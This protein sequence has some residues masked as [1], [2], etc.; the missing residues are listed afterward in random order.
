MSAKHGLIVLW[1][2]IAVPYAFADIVTI[3]FEG[4]A[5]G[6]QVTAQ[7][8]GVTFTNATIA[9]S[10]I[11][12]DPVE[13]PP[14]S[15]T[16]VIFDDGGPMSI[17]FLQSVTNFQAFFTY[18]EP[19]TLTAFDASNQIVA[20]ATSTYNAN[21]GSSGNPPD[22]LLS[23]SFAGGISDITLEADP[24]G[25]SFVMDDMTYTTSDISPS[26]SEPSFLY[27]L[28]SMVGVLWGCKVMVKQNF[29]VR[30]QP[31]STA[32]ARSVAEENGRRTRRARRSLKPE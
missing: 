2:T 6:T 23:L 11:S 13:F 24:A 27:L 26:T 10:F 9:S 21:Y 32:K 5:D 29:A 25:S 30:L 31:G 18:A 4:L 14:E 1:A 7:Y 8:S 15:G 3:D 22:E 12:L 17:A 16:N 19:L 28:A 20:T